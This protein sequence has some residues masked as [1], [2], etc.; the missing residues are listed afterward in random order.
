MSKK[1]TGEKKDLEAAIRN[2]GNSKTLHKFYKYAS[3]ILATALFVGTISTNNFSPNTLISNG[4]SSVGIV[5]KGR[6]K[7]LTI[8]GMSNRES[9][10][11]SHYDASLPKYKF[12]DLSEITEENYDE[13]LLIN[14]AYKQLPESNSPIEARRITL[15]NSILSADEINADAIE[16]KHNSIIEPASKNILY[17][18]AKSMDLYHSKIATSKSALISAN[19]MFL[20]NSLLEIT[21]SSTMIN[22][23]NLALDNSKIILNNSL[24]KLNIND[25]T[26]YRSSIASAQHDIVLEGDNM[27]LIDSAIK[28][29]N[30]SSFIKIGNNMALNNS[31]VSSQQHTVLRAG[32]LINL[33]NESSIS[34]INGTSIVR[35]GNFEIQDLSKIYGVNCVVRGAGIKKIDILRKYEK[36]DLGKVQITNE[37]GSISYGSYGKSKDK[38]DPIPEISER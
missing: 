22:V 25:L 36:E 6:S 33:T 2:S 32:N 29:E 10:S 38:I 31:R 19:N 30:E 26:L 16:L 3:I 12:D 15:I 35:T 37:E 28:S 24:N 23:K 4:T 9:I 1:Y 7:I 8:I 27:Q 20:K 5:K 11:S 13:I 14:S 18:T 34:S 17:I 21:D